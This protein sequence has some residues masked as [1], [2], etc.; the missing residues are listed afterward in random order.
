VTKR[1]AHERRETA[2]PVLRRGG[3]AVREKGKA[4]VLPDCGFHAACLSGADQKNMPVPRRVPSRHRRHPS[5]DTIERA[6]PLGTHAIPKAPA[7]LLC[8]RRVQRV[9]RLG[10]KYRT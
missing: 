1:A 10:W 9:I 2:Q 4:N 3:L 8:L 7:V 5:P 6:L